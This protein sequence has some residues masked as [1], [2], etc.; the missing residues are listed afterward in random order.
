MKSAL[1]HVSEKNAASLSRQTLPV[2]QVNPLTYQPSIERARLGDRGARGQ[3]ALNTAAGL[4][5]GAAAVDTFF[6][7]V[8]YAVAAVATAGLGRVDAGR[9]A[10]LVVAEVGPASSSSASKVYV[11]P[12]WLVALPRAS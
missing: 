10:P 8:L 7:A 9:V 3:G 2:G 5:D 11:L 1:G 6:V 12:R 4:A